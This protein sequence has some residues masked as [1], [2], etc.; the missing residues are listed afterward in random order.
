M[1]SVYF[2]DMA[3]ESHNYR[4]NALLTEHQISLSMHTRMVILV[5]PRLH[6]GKVNSYKITYYLHLQNIFVDFTAAVF[7][8]LYYVVQMHI[9]TKHDTCHQNRTNKA[10]KI[11][12]NYARPF[13]LFIDKRSKTSSGGKSDINFIKFFVAS[14]MVK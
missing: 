13:S 12:T 8:Q 3:R 2:I 11:V 7:V 9:E 5:H 4:F 6:Q 14:K 1:P 10:N